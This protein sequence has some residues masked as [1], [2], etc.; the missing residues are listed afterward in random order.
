MRVALVA[1]LSLLSAS[2]GVPCTLIGCQSGVSLK[3]ATTEL[4]TLAEGPSVLRLCIDS[5]CTEGT[6]DGTSGSFA[7]A[8][9]ELTG[10]SLRARRNDAGTIDRAAISLTITRGGTERFTRTW[11]DVKFAGQ[12]PNGAGCGEVCR[13]ANVDATTP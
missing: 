7:T 8:E 11:Q 12:F 2:C 4:Q 5:S 1:A 6:V 9:F 3:L 10:S 13:V